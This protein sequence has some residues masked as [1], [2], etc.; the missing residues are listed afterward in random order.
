MLRV[1][2][3]PVQV[4]DCLHEGFSAAHDLLLLLRIHLTHTLITIVLLVLGVTT[5]TRRRWSGSITGIVWFRF[6]SAN[7]RTKP[8]LELFTLIARQ[9]VSLIVV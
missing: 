7:I 4:L 5:V 6:E 2:Q 9:R 3:L 8:Y 1:C